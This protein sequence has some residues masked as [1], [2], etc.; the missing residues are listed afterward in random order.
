MQLLIQKNNKLK[1]YI[2]LSGKLRIAPRL[3]NSRL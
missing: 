3:K 1:I 2:D